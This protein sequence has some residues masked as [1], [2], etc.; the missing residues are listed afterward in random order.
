[1]CVSGS[2]SSSESE[3]P[4]K[5][6]FWIETAALRTGLAIVMRP[7]GSDSLEYELRHIQ[8]EGI[9]TL[10]SFLEHW[11]ARSLGLGREDAVCKQIGLRFVSYPMRDGSTPSDR[12]DFDTF[13]SS[14]A[15]R[16]HTGERVGVHCRGCIGRSTVVAACTLIKLGW[17][18]EQALDA[19]EAARGCAVPDTE[20]QREFILDFGKND[21]GA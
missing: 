15:H 21:N 1:M 18:A 2:I 17:S 10:V 5:D 19:I 14:L 16:L 6:I 7:Q 9:Q 11:E 12:E 4:V 13:V 20:E 8:R 3:V